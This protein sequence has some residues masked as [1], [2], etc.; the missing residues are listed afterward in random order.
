MSRIEGE[1]KYLV[2]VS[3]YE[4]YEEQK[5]NKEV[6]SLL[7]PPQNTF[8]LTVTSNSEH[9]SVDTNND[10]EKMIFQNTILVPLMMKK[11]MKL[12]IQLS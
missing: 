9:F 6:R 1:S 7:P 10:E 4:S 12:K 5:Q 3:V 8:D 11:M 2:S